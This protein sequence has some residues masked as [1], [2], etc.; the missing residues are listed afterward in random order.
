[1]L[2]IGACEV[3]PPVAAPRG[4]VGD[5]FGW[6]DRPSGPDNHTGIDVGAPIGWPVL[7]VFSGK[8]RAVY[9]SGELS[10][11]GNLIVLEHGTRWTGAPLF[12][13]YAHLRSRP[14]LEV[15]ASVISGQLVGE[16]GDTGGTREDPSARTRG[17]H[18]HFELLSRWLPRGKDL[19]RID[20]ALVLEPLGLLLRGRS[21]IAIVRGSPADCGASALERRNGYPVL[22]SRSS[23]RGSSVSSGALPLVLLW[24][25]SSG[26]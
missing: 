4:W 25:L 9:A 7:A 19:D 20:P 3:S 2:P 21:K 16:V 11:Y 8:V 22:A 12:S 24:W 6:R 10:K 17:P 13:L 23:A 15:G 18:L 26:G 5:P 1:M 14:A